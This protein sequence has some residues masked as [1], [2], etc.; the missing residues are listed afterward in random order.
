MAAI[1]AAKDTVPEG[2]KIPFLLEIVA[3]FTALSHPNH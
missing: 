3:L 1:K 2:K